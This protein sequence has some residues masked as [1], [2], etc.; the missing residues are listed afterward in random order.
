LQISAGGSGVSGRFGCWA[1]GGCGGMSSSVYSPP[2]RLISDEL[3]VLVEPLICP[4]LPSIPSSASS[5][6]SSMSNHPTPPAATAPT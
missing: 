1:G 4:E 5:T 2:P 6:P 3:W